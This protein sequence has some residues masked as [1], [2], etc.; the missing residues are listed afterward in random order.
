MSVANNIKETRIKMGVS[1]QELANELGVTRQ[2]ISKWETGISCPDAEQVKV[3]SSKLDIPAHVLLDENILEN[4][5]NSDRNN[6]IES[7][8]VTHKLNVIIC[9][10]LMILSCLT[11]PYG[12]I[13]AVVN[14]IY[15]VRNKLGKPI[16]LVTVLILIFAIYTFVAFFVPEIAIG[17][18]R[19]S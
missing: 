7:P 1:Q 19:A 14:V 6:S 15:S 13:A 3:L 2:L 5:T 18:A 12:V 17:W 10:V 16:V 8:V 11:L 9:I 4:T